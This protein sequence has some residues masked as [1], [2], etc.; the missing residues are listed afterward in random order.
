MLIVKKKDGTLRLCIDYRQLNKVTIKNRYPFQ[1]ID[2]LFDGLKGPIVFSKID[3]RSGYRQVRIKEEDIHK[4]SF[5]TKYG[6]Y[7]FMV[8]PFGLTNAP[9]TFMCLV[10]SVLRPYLD[11][12][13]IMFI[14]D[15]LIYSKNEEE[16]VEHLAMV[17]ILLREHQLYAKLSKCNLFHTEVNYLGHVVSKEG[18]FR[19][20]LKPTPK[21]N[22]MI[23]DLKLET[24]IHALKMW[25]HYLLGRR[26]VLMSDHIGLRYLFDQPNLNVRQ[27]RWLETCIEFDFDIKYIKGKENRVSYYL[28]RRVQVNHIAAMSSYETDLKELVLQ[29]GRHDDK[30]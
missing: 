7:E 8:V 10:N 15:I 14:F 28:S 13:V 18:N 5:H 2:D 6:H 30:Y 27:S 26:F 25:R 12:F 23:H 21:H 11:K 24:S 20:G 1:R 17:L 19:T 9:T 4:S 16:H 3:L 29:T 22:Y